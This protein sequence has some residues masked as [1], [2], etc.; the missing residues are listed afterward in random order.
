MMFLLGAALIGLT[1]AAFDD[2]FP[3]AD[4]VGA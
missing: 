1:W 2:D 3:D 4:A